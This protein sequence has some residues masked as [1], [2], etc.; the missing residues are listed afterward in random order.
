LVVTGA[1]GMLSAAVIGFLLWRGA[2]RV[3]ICD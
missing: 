3:R 2:R 1:L